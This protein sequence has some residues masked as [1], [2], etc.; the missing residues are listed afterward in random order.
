MMNEEEWKEGGVEDTRKRGGPTNA[1]DLS[2]AIQPSE[3]VVG[4]VL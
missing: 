1:N 3:G 2:R 4:I